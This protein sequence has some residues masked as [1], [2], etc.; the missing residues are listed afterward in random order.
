LE[1]SF[2]HTAASPRRFGSEL[3]TL[4]D[5]AGAPAALRIIAGPNGPVMRAGGGAG[6]SAGGAAR[7]DSEGCKSR[8]S[9]PMTEMMAEDPDASVL[10][11]LVLSGCRWG[12]ETGARIF[13]LATGPLGLGT[14]SR[15]LRDHGDGL[16]VISRSRR[17]NSPK[18]RKR[19]ALLGFTIVPVR[20]AMATTISRSPLTGGRSTLGYFWGS[21]GCWV[22]RLLWATLLRLAA[23]VEEEA[24]RR[25]GD[26]APG[27]GGL[28]GA[29][30]PVRTRFARRTDA[31]LTGRRYVAKHPSAPTAPAPTTS[32]RHAI[33]ASAGSAARPDFRCSHPDSRARSAVGGHGERGP[34]PHLLG[35]KADSSASTIGAGDDRRSYQRRE[36]GLEP[37]VYWGKTAA[38]IGSSSFVF[39]DFGPFA[40]RWLW[41]SRPRR[42]LPAASRVTID[43]DR[44]R[45][46]FRRAGIE[47][48]RYASGRHA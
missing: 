30:E 20:H 14:V 17:S 43:A 15:R 4:A 24:R 9:G 31:E 12:R 19:G 28:E 3:G 5:R 2:H 37:R 1:R 38:C 42:G 41:E 7:L 25:T 44:D 32:E 33:R 10:R 22:S 48:T 16:V 11:L 39:R 13:F 47:N 26:G 34:P 29:N 35:A 18:E 6:P 45:G 46:G 23:S 21:D 40:G 36:R 8:R 27:E